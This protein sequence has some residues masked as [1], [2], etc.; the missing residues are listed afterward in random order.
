MNFKNAV[1]VLGAGASRGAKVVGGKTPPLDI[2]FLST[3]ARYFQGKKARGPNREAVKAWK[4]LKAHLKGA[5]LG[6]N[7]VRDWRLEQ[8]STFLEARASLRGVQLGQGRPR[9]FAAALDA[10]KMLVCH[11]LRA[12]GGSRPCLFHRALFALVQPSAV[13]SFN[14]DLIADQSMLSSK[15]LNWRSKLYRGAAYA[16]VP[17]DNGS[18]YVQVSARPREQG[19]PLLKL[20]GSMNWEK[21]R[22]GDGF[23]LSGCKLPGVAD[24]LFEYKQVPRKPYIVPPI[25]AKIQ[26]TQSALR[27]RWRS[28][29]HH[30]HK[31]RTWVIWGYS[32]P[33]T[34]TISQ[35]LFRAALA[36]NRRPK[37]VLVINPDAS[38]ASRVRV[39]CRKVEVSHYLSI[40]RLLLD[41]GALPLNKVAMT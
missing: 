11:V 14:Y 17:T 23:R 35:V 15:L 41:E 5:G 32:F 37:R 20:H 3:A 27:E 16:D 34:D 36:K 38:V 26:I 4:S 29:V 33:G 13:I 28:A 7:E 31:A 10:L 21:L 22:R 6:F 39:V 1:I 18:K 25:A 12:E 2:E 24:G 19:T 30:L 40:E 9:D 8:L